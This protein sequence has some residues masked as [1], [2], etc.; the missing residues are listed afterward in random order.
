MR[1]SHKLQKL[2]AREPNVKTV[3]AINNA[4]RRE[5]SSNQPAVLDRVTAE[6]LRKLEDALLRTKQ[7]LMSDKRTEHQQATQQRRQRVQAARQA[8]KVRNQN[9]PSGEDDVYATA[10]EDSDTAEEQEAQAKHVRQRPHAPATTRTLTTE[11]QNRSN[12][13]IP[14]QTTKTAAS[15]KFMGTATSQA[16]A[17]S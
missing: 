7:Q 8:A 4:V 12:N 15:V 17:S 6:R 13:A 2:R 5:V 3:T 11:Q 14:R 16:T 10:R 9:L 1:Q